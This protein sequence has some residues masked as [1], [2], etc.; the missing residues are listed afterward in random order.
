MGGICDSEG[1]G[2]SRE[3]DTGM[4]IRPDAVLMVLLVQEWKILKKVA[5]TIVR[6]ERLPDVCHTS[7]PKRS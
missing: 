1:R 7:L 4:K 5:A 6:I 2:G 3:V